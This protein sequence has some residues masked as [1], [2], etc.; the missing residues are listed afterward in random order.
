MPDILG[1]LSRKVGISTRYVCK[2]S[3]EQPS[4]NSVRFGVWGLGFGVWGLGFGVW[5][6][7]F[8]V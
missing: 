5:G 1:I 4:G 7:G 6:L 3:F 8:G 2:W